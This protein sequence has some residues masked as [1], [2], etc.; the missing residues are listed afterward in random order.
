MGSVE[1]ILARPQVATNIAT[2][3][4]SAIRSLS[5]DTFLGYKVQ[6]DIQRIRGVSE[7][8]HG[9]EIDSGLG[10]GLYTI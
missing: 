8:A 10:N 4:S 2:R 9:N 7:S 5:L 3:S 6:T 1:R